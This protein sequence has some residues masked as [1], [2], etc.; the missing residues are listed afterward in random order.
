M[1]LQI[2][3][4]TKLLLLRIVNTGANFLS[5]HCPE[6]SIPSD[7][8]VNRKLYKL[9]NYEINT[10]V[11][12]FPKFT[13]SNSVSAVFTISIKNI[14]MGLCVDSMPVQ[15]CTSVRISAF[16]TKQPPFLMLHV[17]LHHVVH[18]CSTWPVGSVDIVDIGFSPLPPFLI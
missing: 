9:Q 10:A 12:V 11:N 6:E 4:N 14:D 16:S 2:K 13:L 7:V 15:L 18:V 8:S 1:H 17:G 5:Y 3:I